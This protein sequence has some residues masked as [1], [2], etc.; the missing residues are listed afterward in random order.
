MCNCVETALASVPT[1][2]IDQL[3]VLVIEG[4]LLQADVDELDSLR[5]VLAACDPDNYSIK[6]FEFEV[7]FYAVIHQAQPYLQVN[8]CASKS[9]SC[10]FQLLVFMSPSPWMPHYVLNPVHLR[11]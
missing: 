9:G 7:C 1:E 8:F 5:R 3:T 11:G 4:D 2:M 6:V 10:I